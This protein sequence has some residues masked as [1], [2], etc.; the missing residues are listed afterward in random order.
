M[1]DSTYL[2]R[3]IRRF[4]SAPKFDGYSKV[5]LTVSDEVE[6]VAGDETG[7][8]LRIENPWGTPHMAQDI[9]KDIRGFEYQPY[10]AEDAYID[11]AAE[12][13]TGVT[14]NNVYSGI[15]AQRLR[16]GSHLTATVS[17]PGDEDI[18][19][20]YPYKPRQDRKITRES[21]I[22]RA[23]LMVEL[24]KISASVEEQK[25]AVEKLSSE[26]TLQSGKIEAK[27]SKT[28]GDASSFGW[29]LLDNSWTVKGNNRDI[30]KV[31]ASGA[32]VYGKITA[33]SGEIGGFGIH[34]DYLNYNKHTWD[35]PN[36]VGVYLG[37]LGIRIG[38]NFK[39]DNLGNLYA[40][41]GHFYGSIYASSILFGDKEGGY[42]SGRALGVNTLPGSR[43][44][45]NTVD[46]NYTSLGINSS[47]GRADAAYNYCTGVSTAS[48]FIALE[49]QGTNKISAKTLF[50]SGTE[51]VAKSVTF[52]DADGD[53]ITIAYW[54]WG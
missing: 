16:F 22:L 41:S 1:A 47:L 7:R 29:E 19:H 51:V 3:S 28:G 30:F 32:E 18:N 11:P 13:G 33:T 2:G 36:A 43:L 42:V 9:L 8:V 49:I 12:L 5:I 37:S 38:Q 34:S 20:E 53:N 14:V 27:V 31:T 23:S 10:T 26:L 35:G 21:K 54:G 40:W 6:Y 52:K 45:P 15:Y 24:G 39:V 48:K 17:A 50:V 4:A 46:T 44:V 25:S